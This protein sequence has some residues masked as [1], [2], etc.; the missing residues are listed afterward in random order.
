MPAVA[1]Q[2]DQ[3]IAIPLRRGSFVVGVSCA[4][5]A[6]P[7]FLRM[8]MSGSSQLNAAP[9]SILRHQERGP[10]HDRYYPAPLRNLSLFGQGPARPRTQRPSLGIGC[11]SSHH[12]KTQPDVA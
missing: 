1:D 4:I 9:S 6:V 10:P 3:P 8:T 7:L 12:A 5:A 11:N 2:P